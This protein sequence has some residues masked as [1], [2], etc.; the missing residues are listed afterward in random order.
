MPHW[1][2]SESVENQEGPKSSPIARRTFGAYVA[3]SA[4]AAVMQPH[5]HGAV[6][7][8]PSS[9]NNPRPTIRPDHCDRSVSVCFPLTLEQVYFLPTGQSIPLLRREALKNSHGTND[10]YGQIAIRLNNLRNAIQVAGRLGVS[11]Q[12]YFERDAQTHWSANECQAFYNLHQHMTMPWL[13]TKNSAD[14]ITARIAAA[15][16]LQNIA[17]NYTMYDLV[18]VPIDPSNNYAPFSP[19]DY[20]YIQAARKSGILMDPRPGNG[21]PAC[22]VELASDERDKK[23][24]AEPEGVND[25]CYC[26]D[27]NGCEDSTNDD[28]NL[29]ANDNPT[30]M[31]DICTTPCP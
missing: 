19:T 14:K 30:M 10:P 23:G 16:N 29:D 27:T 15:T 31:S 20:G 9:T 21:N 2:E 18:L 4:A 13:T 11:F 7:K 26:P 1:E 8:R 5:A 6:Y 17:H 25:R 12:W 24:G 22:N 3:A 28:C